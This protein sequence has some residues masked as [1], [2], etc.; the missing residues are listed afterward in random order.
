MTWT[1]SPLMAAA[2]KNFRTAATETTPPAG[3][4]RV[5]GLRSR[6]FGVQHTTMVC[7]QRNSV[8]SQQRKET[9]IS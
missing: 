6:L 9:S 8:S 3:T 2:E 5:E 1:N 4:R 7:L